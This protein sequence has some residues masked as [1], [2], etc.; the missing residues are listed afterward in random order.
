MT[1]YPFRLGTNISCTDEYE[2]ELIND[3][4]KHQD[5]AENAYELKRI[6]AGTN[7]I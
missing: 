7:E 5:E 4:Q 3:K 6:D 2:I 1:V